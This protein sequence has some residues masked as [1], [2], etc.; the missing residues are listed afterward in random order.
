M[1][2][3]LHGLANSQLNRSDVTRDYMS[4][5]FLHRNTAIVSW[6]FNF[7]DTH[8]TVNAGRFFFFLPR[9]GDCK[10]AIFLEA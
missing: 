1:D 8:V 9:Y 4:D 5:D 10:P 3:D 7:F 6:V 2:A